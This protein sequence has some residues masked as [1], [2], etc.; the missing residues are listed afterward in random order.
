MALHPLNYQ[1]TSL[2]VLLFLITTLISPHF[3]SCTWEKKLSALRWTHVIWSWV[4]MMVV[5]S[6]Q[7]FDLLISFFFDFQ[8]IDFHLLEDQ[9]RLKVSQE[10]WAEELMEE[11]N[12]SLTWNST[13]PHRELNGRWRNHPIGRH[14]SL[15]LRRT[16]VCHWSLLK[17]RWSF[18]TQAARRQRP[19]CWPDVLAVWCTL[20]LLRISRSALNA[21]AQFCLML[22]LTNRSKNEK[23]VQLNL[24]SLAC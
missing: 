15:Y 21:R 12:W 20:C 13:Y 14:R 6:D 17:M 11:T 5:F 3:L 7:R 8:G 23:L 4:V 10:R 19:W 24:M 2:L 18:G 16:H 22:F 1:T 9:E